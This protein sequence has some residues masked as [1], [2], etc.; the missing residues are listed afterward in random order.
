MDKKIKQVRKD[1]EQGNKKKA[2]KDIGSLL[3]ADKKFDKEI[4]KCHEKKGKKG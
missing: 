1:V 4:E 3:K 2:E